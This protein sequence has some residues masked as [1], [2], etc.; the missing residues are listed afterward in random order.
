MSTPNTLL[1]R[2]TWLTGCLALGCALA[3][4]CQVFVQPPEKALDSL[5]QPIKAAPDSVSLEVFQ[6]RIPLDQDKKAECRDLTHGFTH[7]N[8]RLTTRDNDRRPV[9]ARA[10][11]AE[12]PPAAAPR[13]G[14][15]LS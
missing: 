8:R 12:E 4:G 7:F 11:T 13:R 2:R 9:A 15:R 14:R 5:L 6:A 1:C 10:G 3:T